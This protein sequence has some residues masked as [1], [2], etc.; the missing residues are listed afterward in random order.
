MTLDEIVAR[1]VVA[2]QE[3]RA[4]DPE[5]YREYFSFERMMERMRRP[6][7]VRGVKN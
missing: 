2:C 6:I 3:L 7:G 5:G 1:L 4:R